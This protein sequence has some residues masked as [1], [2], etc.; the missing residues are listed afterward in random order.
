MSE[1]GAHA[2]RPPVLGEGRGGQPRSSAK[3]S[4][5]PAGGGEGRQAGMVLRRL[6]SSAP[7][8][9][10][11]LSDLGRPPKRPILS[12][13]QGAPSRQ[14]F[15]LPPFTIFAHLEGLVLISV[16]SP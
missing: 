8:M 2:R 16:I 13:H 14:L 9:L 15:S 10:L 3:G 1:R 11:A 6:P 5:S 12:F 4:S 7:A